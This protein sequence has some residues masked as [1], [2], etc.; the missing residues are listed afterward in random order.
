MADRFG[1]HIPRPSHLLLRNTALTAGVAVAGCALGLAAALRPDWLLR[2]DRPLS[3]AL[4]GESLIGFFRFWTQLGSQQDM[5]VVAVVLAVLLWRKCPSFAVAVPFAVLVG[6]AVDVSVKVLVD[7]PRPP[8]A[9][10]GTALGSFPSGH[11]LTGVILF[12]LLPPAVWVALRRR[13]LFWVSVPVAA[14]VGSLV[15]ASRVYLGAHWPS[16]VLASLLLGAAILLF[17]EYLLGTRLAWH[18]RGD[19]PLHRLPAPGPA[20]PPVEAGAAAGGSAARRR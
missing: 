5:L 3:D 8:D 7:R 15:V 18:R 20:R 2:I 16:D 14:V 19:C 4:R 17:T 11:A 10:V 6:I 13:L 9:V 12:G 1:H